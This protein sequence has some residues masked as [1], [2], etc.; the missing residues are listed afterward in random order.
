MATTIKDGSNA[1]EKSRP[2]SSSSSNQNIDSPRARRT[3]PKPLTADSSAEKKATP[4]YLKHTKS[5]GKDVCIYSKN[6]ASDDTN[7]KYSTSSRRKSTD[8]S[9]TQTSTKLKRTM[10]ANPRVKPS[11]STRPSSVSATPSTKPVG[12]ST[13]N[14]P[15]LDKTTK[16][17]PLRGGK[18]QQPVLTRPMS[19]KKGTSSST[20]KKEYRPKTSLTNKA[21]PSY[22]PNHEQEIEIKHDEETNM[23]LEQDIVSDE[24]SEKDGI[25]REENPPAIDKVEPESKEIEDDKSNDH[26]SDSLPTILSGEQE[27]EPNPTKEELK[28]DNEE[29]EVDLKQG[30]VIEESS[31]E[32]SKPQEENEVV[33]A[34]K[35]ETNEK[36]VIEEAKTDDDASKLSFKKG[37]ELEEKEEE[38]N[39]NQ[40]LKF[41]ERAV[42]GAEG[43]VGEAKP[44]Q[45]NVVLKRQDVQGK[46][47]TQAYNDVIEETASKLVEKRKSKVKAL[48]GAFETVISLEND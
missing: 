2:S 36:L 17:T 46:K 8:P 5:S 20:T 32:Q 13:S 4:N 37:K 15:V 9:P 3:T 23:D 25:D 11:T 1:K 34:K 22:K 48:V 26:S 10:S 44:E 47:E 41:K 39:G 38:G 33:A 24:L 35:E 30:N 6:Q 45:E 31:N 12:G 27:V 19:I 14:K 29:Q 18:A 43:D 21:Q 42:G 16:T 7:L 28:E 40:R